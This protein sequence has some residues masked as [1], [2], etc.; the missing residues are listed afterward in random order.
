MCLCQLDG[1][2]LGDLLH[3]AACELGPL[4]LF[5]HKVLLQFVGRLVAFP[6]VRLVKQA[7]THAQQ[8]NTTWFQKL[9]GWVSDDDFPGLLAHGPFSVQNAITP[10]RDKW[11]SNIYICQIDDTKVNTL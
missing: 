3:I 10:L 7:F 4:H 5:W 11:F 9:S 2:D 6:N 8:Q 1:T